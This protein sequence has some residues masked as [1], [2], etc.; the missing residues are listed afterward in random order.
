MRWILPAA[1]L[2]FVSCAN[3]REPL[4]VGLKSGTREL[5]ERTARE[6][7][8]AGCVVAKPFREGDTASLDAALRDG[9]IDLYVESHA[10]ALT[11][12][13]HKESLAGPAAESAVRAAYLRSDLLWA[14]RFP[15][16]DQAVVYRK[17]IDQR[18]RS[19]ARALMLV[20]G[21]PGGAR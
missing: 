5:T 12:V 1:L 14:P 17:D 13:L 11:L 9:T 20:T 6:L 2:F 10:A 4:R 18:C 19:A 3:S 7:E 16:G 21:S 8:R 15:E